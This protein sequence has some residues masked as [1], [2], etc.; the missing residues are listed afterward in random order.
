VDN[1]VTLRRMQV[2]CTLVNAFLHSFT[3]WASIHH[4]SLSCNR[5]AEYLPD[6]PEVQAFLD[7]VGR[8]SELSP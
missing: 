7:L 2:S 8:A 1:L 3:S 5:V 6:D 4:W